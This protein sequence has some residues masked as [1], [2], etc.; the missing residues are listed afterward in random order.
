P[1]EIIGELSDELDSRSF[2][3]S[4]NSNRLLPSDD[5][6]FDA[7]ATTS[8][9]QEALENSIASIKRLLEVRVEAAEYQFFLRMLYAGVITAL[10]TYL[11]DRFIS[12]VNDDPLIRRKFVETTPDFKV[13]KVPLSDLFDAEK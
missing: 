4:P 9:H 2:E 11:S 5:Y 7:S 8:H 10:E 3:W 1:D 6:F 13:Q 12:S